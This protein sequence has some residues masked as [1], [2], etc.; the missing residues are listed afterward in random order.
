[1]NF[2][3]RSEGQRST[4][5]TISNINSECESENNSNEHLMSSTQPVTGQQ[6]IPPTHRSLNS[7]S[8]S[9]APQIAETIREK[10]SVIQDLSQNVF[11]PN[12]NFATYLLSE[13]KTLNEQAAASVRKSVTMFFLQCIDEER[14]KNFG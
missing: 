1:M 6:S 8:P 4:R 3:G 10:V 2:I 12:I 7:N 5:Q 14:K 9:A 13:L 11:D